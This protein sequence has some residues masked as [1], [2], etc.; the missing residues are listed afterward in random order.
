MTTLKNQFTSSSAHSETFQESAERYVVVL[1]SLT[2]MPIVG[3]A[4]QHRKTG[5]VSILASQGIKHS[6]SDF[7]QLETTAPYLIDCINHSD[8]LAENPFIKENEIRSIICVPKFINHKAYSAVL[9]FTM[10]YLPNYVSPCRFKPLLALS[11]TL[12]RELNSIFAKEHIRQEMPLLFTSKIGHL[13]KNPL[14]NIELG[15]SLLARQETLNPSK[16][17]ETHLGLIAN[18]IVNLR[19]KIEALTALHREAFDYQ[20]IKKDF[21]SD[22]LLRSLKV[23]FANEHSPIQ[24]EFES[25]TYFGDRKALFACAEEL[26][27]NALKFSNVH[28]TIKVNFSKVGT[29]AQLSVENIGQWINP[30]YY[31]AI[32]QPFES[33]LPL[34]RTKQKIR[35]LGLAKV[36]LLVENMDGVI[37]VDSQKNGS[38]TFTIDLNP[39]PA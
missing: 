27:D 12:Q 23:R 36:K 3:I 29:R 17:T 30:K 14:S 35:G 32:F 8:D 31:S 2:D 1:E 25:F 7:P 21:W 24:F 15:L 9:I 11:T 37:W 33:S 22:E 19:L 6:I 39:L 26:I 18:S 34:L 16:S 20:I 4:L 38:T 5:A 10:D 13:F 28:T